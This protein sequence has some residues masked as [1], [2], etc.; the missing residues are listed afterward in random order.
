MYEVFEAVTA[1]NDRMTQ[2]AVAAEQ[3]TSAVSEVKEQ[4]SINDNVR[5]ANKLSV[6]LK[7][8]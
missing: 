4:M 8:K 5:G 7:A 6:I 1:I 3:H 2:I